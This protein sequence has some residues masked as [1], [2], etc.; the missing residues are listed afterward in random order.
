MKDKKYILLISVLTQI[1]ASVNFYFEY[2]ELQ[3]GSI[4]FMHFY[5]L[6]VISALLT[7]IVFFS[8]NEAKNIIL[9]IIRF[10][11]FTLIGYPMGANIFIETI[12]FIGII[13]ESVFYLKEKHSIILMLA[14]NV[15]FLL[16]QQQASAWYER[17]DSV[18]VH[19]LFSA[20]FINII[21]TS[22][23]YVLKAAII[24]LKAQKADILFMNSAIRQLSDINIGFQKF[25]KE[26][27]FKILLEERKRLSREIHD[28]VGYTLTNIIMMMEVLQVSE[29]RRD[30]K[31]EELIANT[32]NQALRGLED[33]RAALRQLRK[34][35]IP[36]KHGKEMIYELVSAFRLASGIDIQINFGNLPEFIDYEID[37]IIF[38]FVQEGMTNVFRHGK[39][40]KVGITFWNSD[41]KL[42]VK[43]EDNG[44]G[45]AE[46]VEGIGLAGMR[47][48]LQ[49]VNGEL[50]LKNM[51]RGFKAEIVIPVCG[52]GSSVNGKD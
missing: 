47:E 3:I 22:G 46:I 17:L 50:I 12:L 33:T 16:P 4:F 41:K 19:N 21:F 31:K 10:M 7:V 40:S 42:R 43:I 52:T 32:K 27:E 35:E 5:I 44:K 26:Q 30:G 20:G 28:T 25:V 37:Q 29:D 1:A 2:S 48:R 51:E 11:I 15:G 49:R 38:S 45:A 36:Q 14:F 13:A 39:A 23:F 18:S 24:R 6:V 8:E 34:K 9:L